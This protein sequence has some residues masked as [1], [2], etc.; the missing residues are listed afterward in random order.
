[1][2]LKR[3]PIKKYAGCSG[4][5]SKLWRWFGSV[6]P[7]EHCCDDHDR[8]YAKGGTEIARFCADMRLYFCVLENGWPRVA[9]VMF[10][11]VRYG[12]VPWL[13]TPYRWGFETN[14]WKYDK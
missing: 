9:R 10:F 11:M 4:G 6:P 1:M 7:W 5:M 8:P 3:K 13:P 2:P 12:G 14:K